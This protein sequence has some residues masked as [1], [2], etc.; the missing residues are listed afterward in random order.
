MLKY[1]TSE[2]YHYF[3]ITIENIENFTD[4]DVSE[5]L[6]N[7]IVPAIDGIDYANTSIDANS[8]SNPYPHTERLPD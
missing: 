4:N 8:A 2:K 1:N 5:F 6:S 3:P 7:I